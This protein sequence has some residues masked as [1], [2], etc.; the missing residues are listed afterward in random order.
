M[1]QK[2]QELIEDSDALICVL[3]DEVSHSMVVNSYL[4]RVLPTGGKP[5]LPPP[6]TSVMH[7]T[8]NDIQQHISLGSS[9]DIIHGTAA[10]N[11]RPILYMATH[12]VTPT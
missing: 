8:G 4:A 1:F 10:A 11:F 6:V 2:I 12:V 7:I 9:I 5:Q 3:I